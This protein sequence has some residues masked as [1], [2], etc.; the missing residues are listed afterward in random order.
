MLKAIIFDMDGV[1][2]NSEPSHADAALA[3]FKKY[4][5]DV[6]ISY[7]KGF[8]GSSTKSMCEDAVK[9]FGIDSTVEELLLEM[10]KAK[11]EII[12]KQGYPTPL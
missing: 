4:N 8:I 1:I 9:R 11:K 6:D 5:A 2:I 3:V 10:N 7:C 12:L